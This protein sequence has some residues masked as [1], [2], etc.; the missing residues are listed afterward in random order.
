M[1]M[2]VSDEAYDFLADAGF[3]AVY[4]ARPLKR[5]IQKELE[6]NIALGILSGEYADGDS[7]VVG[8]MSEGL[9][10]RKAQPWEQEMTVGE[11]G[12]MSETSTVTGFYQ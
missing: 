8:V 2:I 6:N 12:D 9:Q 11:S 1:K 3:D 5:V 7:I 10:I 4:G